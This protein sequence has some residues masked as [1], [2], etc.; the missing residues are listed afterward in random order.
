MKLQFRDPFSVVERGEQSYIYR[1]QNRVSELVSHYVMSIYMT[2]CIPEC[3]LLDVLVSHLREIHGNGQWPP[4]ILYS[5]CTC[6]HV[7][8][9]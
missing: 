3:V 6:I 4:V 9:M 5:V 7:R 2:I 8:N 1:V